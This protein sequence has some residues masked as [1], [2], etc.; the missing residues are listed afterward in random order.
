MTSGYE[1]LKAISEKKLY[2]RKRIIEE[3]NQYIDYLKGNFE[4]LEKRQKAIIRGEA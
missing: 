4:A 2:F 3:K 1:R